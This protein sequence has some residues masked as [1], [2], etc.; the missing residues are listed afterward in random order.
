MPGSL[1][2]Y[3]TGLNLCIDGFRFTKI[4][5]LQLVFSGMTEFRSISVLMNQFSYGC[6]YRPWIGNN[7]CSRWCRVYI[8]NVAKFLNL[9]SLLHFYI[10]HFHLRSP[11]SCWK[12]NVFLCLNCVHC[13]FRECSKDHPEKCQSCVFL[14]SYIFRW[15]WIYYIFT[16]R[17][18]Y[19][20]PKER[21]NGRKNT[22]FCS[23]WHLAVNAG[24]SIHRLLLLLLKNVS[25]YVHLV[26]ALF[27][28]VLNYTFYLLNLFFLFIIKM[29]LKSCN[30]RNTL[31]ETIKKFILTIERCR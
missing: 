26:C 30:S 16:V 14:A 19:C 8:L 5:V 7:L 18:S 3:S 20:C 31:K 24:C 2:L 29:L 22:S 13:L 25:Y 15:K 17:V 11:P 10:L 1:F 12:P 23:W 6:G 27:L 21:K 28:F 4:L 9:N